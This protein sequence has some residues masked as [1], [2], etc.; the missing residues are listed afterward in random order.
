MTYPT[1]FRRHVMSTKEKEGLSFRATACR[2]NIGVTSLLRWS[3]RLEPKAF[4]EGRPRKIDLEKLRQDIRDYPDA[5]QYERAERFGVCQKAI[6]LALRKLN[7]S[8]KKNAATP[9]GRRRREA[10]LPEED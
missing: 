5:Y 10:S 1:D 4:R 2:F 7:V 3:R 8:Y 6:W 9:Q